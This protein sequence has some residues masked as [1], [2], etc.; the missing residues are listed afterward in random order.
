MTDDQ[1][2]KALQHKYDELRMTE[3]YYALTHKSGVYEQVCHVNG[4]RYADA[5]GYD[6]ITGEFEGLTANRPS[7]IE[8][9]RKKRKWLLKAE[10]L[11]GDSFIK[12]AFLVLLGAVATK[13]L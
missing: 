9:R 3:W 13:L 8:V 1:Y 5:I 11:I 7:F 2:Q 12:Q 4:V 6:E 10:M